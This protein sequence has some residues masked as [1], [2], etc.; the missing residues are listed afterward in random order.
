MATS[1]L[2]SSVG[3]PSEMKYNLDY[4]MPPESKSYSI[5]I[6]PSN[7]SQVTTSF[8]TGINATYWGD[9]AM[10]ASNIIFDIP[11]G[12]SPSLFLDNRLTTLNFQMTT[13]FTNVGTIGNGT[14][15]NTYLRA[16]AHSWFDR[17][18]ITSQNGQIIEDITEFALV[19][20][21]LIALQMNQ[22][23]R[24]GSATQYGFQQSAS[25]LGS[26]GHQIAILSAANNAPA[27]AQTETHS[28]SIPLCSGVLGVLAD[29]FLNIG[30]TSKLQ[31]VLQT[32]SVIPITGGINAAWTA[33]ATV[34]VTLSNLSI[35]AEY[36]DI[37]L[38]ALQMLDQTL[39]DG[40]AYSHGIS[41]RTSSAS[42]PAS[43][44][45][46]TSL[47]AG[48][49][50]SSVKSIFTRF[51]QNSLSANNL[52]GKFNSF[53]PS[54]SSINFSIGGLK[55]PQTPI[56]PLLSPS[57]SYRE[58]QIAVGSFNSTQFTSSIPPTL[59]CR[60]SVGS[61]NQG[62]TVGATQ[63][64]TWNNGVDSATA[65]SQYIF[66]QCV[67]TVARRGL[68]SGLNCTSA[69]IFLEMNISQGPTALHNVY[70]IAMID[71]VIVH[72]IRS[73]NI[74]CRT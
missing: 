65:L 60:L 48:I 26:Q 52:H 3:L 38:N 56:N 69:P 21:T 59:Y 4:S 67:E 73:G 40:K 9:M 50:A 19:Q 15:F 57:Q 55:Y 72:D 63:E 17:M 24:S 32:A 44:Q 34:Q 25:I 7:V 23:V 31:L 61:T 41:Y 37:G 68:L 18:Y 29:K 28:Y 20:D 6:Q 58:T 2:P 54:I 66:G 42:L 14:F 71:H 51:A 11:C 12:S 5:R 10:P 62:L 27:L 16:G 22:S 39:V 13:T 45:G 36:V 33:A 47:L 1:Q 35:S 46:N 70:F 43:S 64:Y 30:R 53:N 49:R 74:E 8:S